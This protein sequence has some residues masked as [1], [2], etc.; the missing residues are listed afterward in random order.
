MASSNACWGIEIGSASIKAL[1]LERV[2]ESRVKATDFGIV[3][4]P[5]VLSTPGVDANDV[6]RVSLGQLIGQVDFGKTPVA[7]SVPG[8]S[9]FARF[10]KLPPVEPKKVPEVVR[11][12]AMQQIPFPLEEVEW[13]YQTFVSP[14][15]P[16]VG[17]GIFAIRKDNVRDRLT[18]LTDVGLTPIAITLSPLAVYNAM[19]YDLE[20]N[21]SMPGTI[22]VD[23]GTSSTDIVIAEPGRLWVR[24]F[25]IGG[26]QFTESL[27][28][29][30]NLSYPK[31]E[32]LKRE[33]EDTKHA[34]QVFQAMRPV[35][36]DL[37][38]EIQR[39]IG[40][41]QALYKDSNL[42]RLVGVGSTFRLPGLRKYL[43]QQLGVDVFRVEEFKK[44]APPGMEAGQALA[45][46]LPATDRSVVFQDASLNLVTAYGLALQ[47]LGMNACGGNLM[48]L[49]VS[50][51]AMWKEKTPMFVGAAALALIG[52]AAFFARP[53][54]DYFRV[55]GAITDPV[56]DRAINAARQQ[57]TAADEAG[58]TGTATADL[59]AANVMALF[60]D[61]EVIPR[62]VDDLGE[63]FGEARPKA[64]AK[65]ASLELSSFT[66]VFEPAA[67]AAD[68][69]GMDPM[70]PAAPGDSSVPIEA[71]GRARVRCTL[72]IETTASEAQ[73]FTEDTI[74]S[75]LRGHGTRDGVPYRIVLPVNAV[76][77][78]G[79][80]GSGGGMSPRDRGPGPSP[81]G[82][83]GGGGFTG[84]G[85]GFSPPAGRGGIDGGAANQ[86]LDAMAP[87]PDVEAKSGPVT[88]FT[89]T[90][91]AVLNEAKA[92][93][94]GA[95]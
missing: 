55:R 59:R 20:F 21:E 58:V 87:L 28:S 61:R 50:R 52:S 26:H 77:R 92:T 17:V 13:D 48:P 53:A 88:R 65:K 18:L 83:S 86:S 74:L 41:Y 51:D 93:D 30:F 24:T 44:I 37:S 60:A 89:L 54:Y 36:T 64:E 39:S 70:A 7:V 66:T 11:F 32:R 14:D 84:G 78:S 12:E 19:A 67:S 35:F 31:A 56:V 27:V 15:S 82:L 94:G 95:M 45:Q 75:W 85:G 4:H 68:P 47:G 22:V 49:Q 25:P 34:R 5:K 79:E 46:G 10:T 57:K 73:R 42:T 43:Q 72:T 9:A 38:T 6:L 91:Y 3:Q 1:K 29:Q 80:A 62:I 23:V 71:Q 90:W 8:H 2:D 33:A 16:D 63:M 76:T 69:S 81:T 40:Y